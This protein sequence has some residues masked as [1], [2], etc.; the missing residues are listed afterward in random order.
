M[1]TFIRSLIVAVFSFQGTSGLGANSDLGDLN[2]FQY[3]G[4]SREIKQKERHKIQQHHDSVNDAY[5]KYL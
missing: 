5:G 1:V 4:R 3:P 2:G